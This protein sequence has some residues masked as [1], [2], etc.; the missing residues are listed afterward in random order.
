MANCSRERMSSSQEG[1]NLS[2]ISSGSNPVRTATNGSES[3][4]WFLESL[5]QLQHLDLSG[6]RH[7]RASSLVS[8]AGLT[9]LTQ[10]KMHR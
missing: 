4:L 9:Q 6:W 5:V 10:L 1:K 7:A 8:L 2:A 3:Q